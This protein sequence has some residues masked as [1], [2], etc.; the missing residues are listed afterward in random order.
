MRDEGL[1]HLDS[2]SDAA[3]RA[4]LDGTLAD[5]TEPAFHL[6]EPRGGCRREVKMVARSLGEPRSDP[7]MLAGRVVVQDGM[8]FECGR[9]LAVSEPR[10][11]GKL[12]IAPAPGAFAEHLTGGRVESGEER[13]GSV[14]D[15][16]MVMAFGIARSHRQRGP[17]VMERLYPALLIDAQRHGAVRGIETRA[18]HVAHLIDGERHPARRPPRCVPAGPDHGASK[19]TAR[20]QSAVRAAHL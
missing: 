15:A 1:D 13:R 2:L 19:W 7:R 8:N 20:G 4:S 6:V 11:G 14:P 16:V 5:E 3:E 10:E 17:R 18:S 12:P 9:C